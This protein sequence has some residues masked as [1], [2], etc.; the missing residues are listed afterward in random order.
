MCAQSEAEAAAAAQA[1][2]H[3]AATSEAEVQAAAALA[4]LATAKSAE[5]TAA[6]ADAEMEAAAAAAAASEA[7]A[8]ALAAVEAAKAAA[9]ADLEAAHGAAVA[10]VEAKLAEAVAAR[11]QLDE[12]WQA[13]HAA[14]LAEAAEA[15]AAHEAAALVAVEAK[16]RAEVAAAEA[17]ETEANALYLEEYKKRKVVHN[18][19]IELQG[20]IRVFARARPM[21]TA[22]L[23][24]GKCEDVTQYPTPDDIIITKDSMN[25]V[26]FEFDA[27]FK[28]DSEQTAVFEHVSPFVTSF[29][30]GYNVCIF[31]Y[32]QTG[33]G[34]TWTME[35]PPDNRGVNLRSIDQLFALRDARAKDYD[36]EFVL[37]YLEIYNESVHDLL[38]DPKTS[39]KKVALDVRQGADG[40]VVPGLVSVTVTSTDQV[41]EL[42]GRGAENRAVGSHDMNEHS[43]RSHSIL[44]LNCVGTPKESGSAS[45]KELGPV[46]SKLHLIDLAGS[47]R[48]SKTDATGDRLKEA[49]AIN[50]S[51]SAL[52]DVIAALGGKKGTHVPYRNSRLT[53][54]LQDSLSG[55]S[56]VLMF[57]NVSPASYNVGETVC[58]LTF[59]ARCRN[60]ELGAAKK[61][62]EGPEVRKLKAT[63]AR[64]QDQLVDAGLLPTG[65]GDDGA[66]AEKAKS[67]AKK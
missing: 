9:L 18:K 49:Q 16:A 66:A 20:N 43:S 32:G 28:P 35:G 31:A 23:R 27:V 29:L 4:D 1:A 59:A 11:A 13:R 40:N 64:L 65:D 50:K 24:S 46:K 10:A 63:V 52:G 30:D 2:A 51:L 56:K 58:T 41:V 61:G 5:L 14:A 44:T 3:A 7:H 53:Y 25:R 45:S 48:V 62:G 19:L 39:K 21:V 54:L 22:E 38:V 37:S 17:R 55:N 34:K 8:E 15:A 12:E 33:S 47:E 42:M 26:R 6:V 57:C 36:Y 60:V 67:P